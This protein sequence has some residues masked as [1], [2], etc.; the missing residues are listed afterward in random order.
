MLAIFV[1]IAAISYLFAITQFHASLIMVL[2]VMGIANVVLLAICAGFFRFG[3]A[4][5]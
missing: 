4:K 1:L 5:G 2:K 3:K